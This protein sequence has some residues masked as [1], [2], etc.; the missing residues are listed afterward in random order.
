[1]TNTKHSSK[2]YL[3]IEIAQ[4]PH[5]S[6]AS[7]GW[8]WLGHGHYTWRGQCRWPPSFEASWFAS[9][10]NAPFYQ[11]W[12]SIL[13][14]SWHLRLSWWP[15]GK[16]KKGNT[17]QILCVGMYLYCV[18]KKDRKTSPVDKQKKQRRVA[19]FVFSK[20]CLDTFW[21]VGN[22]LLVEYLFSYLFYIIPGYVR[23]ADSD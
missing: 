10:N 6:S 17:N 4:H 22:W 16:K 11:G 2:N 7:K 9:W 14:Q 12:H 23:P 13:T 1:M 20:S 5:P 19:L 18:A 8:A 3:N 21:K 15:R